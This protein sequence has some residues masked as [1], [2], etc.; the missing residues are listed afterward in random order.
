MKPQADC[1]RWGMGFAWLNRDTKQ[2]STMVYN[3]F[4]L[5]LLRKLAVGLRQLVLESCVSATGS[6][7]SLDNNSM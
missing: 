1:S 4:L 2:P 7:N 6:K 3:T 5:H